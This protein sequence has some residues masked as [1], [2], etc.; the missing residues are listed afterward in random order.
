ML[1][2]PTKK[3]FT[4]IEMLLVISIIG[5]L[6]SIIF[7]GLQGARGRARDAKRLTDLVQFKLA[8][9]F[10]E[11]SNSMIPVGSSATFDTS[12]GEANTV[13]RCDDASA[14]GTW[15]PLSPLRTLVDSGYMAVLPT[16]PINNNGFCYHY[17]ANPEGT[18][19]CVWALLESGE[20][21]GIITGTPSIE[22]NFGAYYPKGFGCGDVTLNGNGLD[23]II[24]GEIGGIGVP[25]ESPSPAPPTTPNPVPPPQPPPTP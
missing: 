3:G 23:R 4:L 12:R 25:H 19:A 11:L 2:F 13:D 24:G 6:S 15:P 10:Y 16:D 17:V 9:D 21:V 20:K 5:L 7:V 8:L 22:T 14:G 1:T 18:G